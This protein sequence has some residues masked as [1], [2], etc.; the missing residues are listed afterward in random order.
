MQISDC[1]DLLYAAMRL[2]NEERMHSVVSFIDDL[3]RDRAFN[4]FRYTLLR[5]SRVLS[6]EEEGV[7]AWIAVNYA[8]GMFSG[9]NFHS[10]CCFNY[11][12]M[13]LLNSVRNI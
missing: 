8:L 4:P 10:I 1:V 2:M 6:G 7:F 3:L 13:K 9:K 12:Y 5:N 11:S